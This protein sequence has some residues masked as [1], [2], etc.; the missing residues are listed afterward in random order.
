MFALIDEESC[1]KKPREESPVE[2][3][4]NS[5][6]K[7]FL[8]DGPCFEVAP[9]LAKC[10]ECRWS[11]QLRSR[12]ISKD[13]FCR[14]YA[15]RRLWYALFTSKCCLG[16][17]SCFYLFGTHSII[18]LLFERGLEGNTFFLLRCQIYIFS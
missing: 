18:C 15:F 10:R 6:R 1:N 14:F 9:K 4:T 5:G 17:V 3:L 7:T 16:E 2:Q 8:Q 13:I 11:T 12:N